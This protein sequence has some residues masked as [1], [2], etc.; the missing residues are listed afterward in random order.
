M[1]LISGGVLGAIPLSGVVSPFLS[2]GNTAMLAN[3]LI[4]G[5]LLAIS[6]H[7]RA[8]SVDEPFRRPVR[9]LEVAL[10]ALR[11]HAARLRGLLSGRARPRISSPRHESFR[12]RRRETGATQSAAEFAGARNPARKYL[13]SQWRFARHQRLERTGAAPRRYEKFGISID[14]ACSR[15][16]NRHYPFG[17]LTAHVLGDLRTGENFHATNASL[18]EHDSNAQAARLHG[19]S[20]A[21]AAG[22]LSPSARK[23]GHRPADGAGPQRDR[24]HRYSP[25]DASRQALENRLAKAHKDKGAAVVMDP[26]TGDVLA[27]VS[28]PAPAARHAARPTSCS[29]APATDSIRR[30]RPSSW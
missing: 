15:L 18:I 6:N 2:S 25:A 20:R 19:L 21:C 14:T 27:M 22:S 8:G 29:I 16:D 17:A 26:H 5:I 4:F 23:S 7:S 1:L 24:V 30:D 10:G 9:S 3:F 11:R 12:R 13:R 28:E